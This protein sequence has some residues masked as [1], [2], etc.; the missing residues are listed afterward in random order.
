MNPRELLP[1]SSGGKT[2]VAPATAISMIA[3]LLLAPIARTEDLPLPN[4]P[5]DAVR[6]T[7]ELSDRSRI[8]GPPIAARLPWIRSTFREVDADWGSS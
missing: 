4:S 2:R 1:F 5:P 8:L 7:A 6:M 3:A